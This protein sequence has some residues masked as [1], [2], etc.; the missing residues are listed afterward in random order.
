MKNNII[1]ES[2]TYVM[3]NLDNI[4]LAFLFMLIGFIYAVLNNISFK[5]ETDVQAKTKKV[6]IYETMENMESTSPVAKDSKPAENNNKEKTNEKNTNEEKE[7]TPISGDKCDTLHGKSHE[8]EAYCEN[9]HP[10][11]CK[12]KKCCVLGKES[13]TGNM[14]C[15]AGSKSGPTY[16]TDE[17][18]NDI[19][20]DYYYFQGKCYGK[21]C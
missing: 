1:S 6:I 21:G 15:V 5:S 17:E 9:L 18:G 3:D 8:I 14:K 10:R 13:D 19:N 12:Q 2:Y 20:L 11:L 4:T 7:E 16:H